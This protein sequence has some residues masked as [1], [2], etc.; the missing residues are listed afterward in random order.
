MNTGTYYLVE[1]QAPPGYNLL[2]RPVKI[3]VDPTSSLTKTV[4]E[5]TEARTYPLYVTYDYYLEGG[6][7]ANLSL[8]YEGIT[9]Q[10]EENE[11]VVKYS[12]TLTV[13]NASGVS[14]PSTGGPGTNMI[15]LLGIIL[16]GFAGAGLVLRRRRKAA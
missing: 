15:Y 9:I 13:P 8:S 5:G 10:E 11:D 4:G 3:T 16:T 6:D 2:T 12:Y 14:L 1:T 7:E